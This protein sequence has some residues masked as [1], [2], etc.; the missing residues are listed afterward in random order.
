TKGGTAVFKIESNTVSGAA[1]DGIFLFRANTS[2]SA[3]SLERGSSASN[4]ASVVLA[5]NNPNAHAAAGGLDTE[6][7]GTITVVNNGTIT[8]PL[9]FAPLGDE[10]PVIPPTVAMPPPDSA[11]MDTVAVV[12]PPAVQPPAVQ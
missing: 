12:V 2:T 1:I 7:S 3:V 8:A 9:L 10:A 5:A 6:V 4:T 11:P